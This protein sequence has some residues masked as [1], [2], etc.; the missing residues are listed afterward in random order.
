MILRTVAPLMCFV[1]IVAPLQV[2]GAPKGDRASMQQA[3][4][5]FKQGRTALKAKDYDAALKFF[6]K[7]QAI[8]EHEPLIIYALAKTLDHAGQFENALRYYQLFITTSEPDDRER[9]LARKRIEALQDRLARRP[10][11]LVLK[12]LAAGAAVKLDGKQVQVDPQNTLEMKAGIH[13]IEVRLGNRI[14]F[15]RNGLALAAGQVLKLEVVL[16][17]PVDPSLLPR[18][19]TWTWVA[20]G[21]TAVAGLALGI[22]AIRRVAL[23]NEYY[24]MVE[25]NSGKVTNATLK[26][27]DCQSTKPEDC[28]VLWKEVSARKDAYDANEGWM[29]ATGIATGVFAIATVAAVFAAPVK[30]GQERSS[31]SVRPTFNGNQLGVLLRF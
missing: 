3:L 25:S 24:E 29:Y 16:L 18:D 30:A 1:L 8:Y 5:V 21:A 12:G 20:G 9:P 27:Y 26:K 7:A 6:R 13:S 11:R 4:E 17:E 22:F 14:P 2:V 19:H 23:L 28:P 15:V 31:V 10:A